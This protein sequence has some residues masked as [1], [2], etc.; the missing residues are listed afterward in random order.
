MSRQHLNLDQPD[1]QLN[2]WPCMNLEHLRGGE[3]Q[4]L[5]RLNNNLLDIRN[6]NFF[7]ELIIQILRCSEPVF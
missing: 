2:C 7:I 1:L 3:L 4:V 5:F 6:H